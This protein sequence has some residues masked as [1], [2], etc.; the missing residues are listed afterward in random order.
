MRVSPEWRWVALGK[1]PGHREAQRREKQVLGARVGPR[2]R[3]GV[4]D[5]Q[6]WGGGV[7][8]MKKRQGQ[9]T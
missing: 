9:G 1:A 2:Q 3:V 5:R 7:G 8:C 6:H 4:E